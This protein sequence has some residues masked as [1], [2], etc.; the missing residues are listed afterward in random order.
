[1]TEQHGGYR[2]ISLV[3]HPD[4]D[5]RLNIGLAFRAGPS[6]HWEVRF[7][8]DW[9]RLQ[10]IEP[11][12]NEEAYGGLVEWLLG[13]REYRSSTPSLDGL[14]ERVTS[15]ATVRVSEERRVS[16]RQGLERETADWLVSR[17][18]DP[19]APSPRKR[20]KRGRKLQTQVSTWLGSK[21]LLSND[22]KDVTSRFVRDFP[23]TD[24]EFTIDF[25]AKN[26]AWHLVDTLDLRVRPESLRKEK[27]GESALAA[28][29]FD[30]AD[31]KLGDGLDVRKYLIYAGP[32]ADVLV[33][34]CL[35]IIRPYGAHV[36]NFE[37]QRGEVEDLLGTVLH[38]H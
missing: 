1:M 34:H 24:T 38:S 22:Q 12:S 26:G 31:K 8:P 17:L 10:A 3:P 20:Y 21:G 11:D 37:T 30:Q 36:Y 35:N 9:R 18:V 28:L 13:M 6:E 23:I 14:L 25:A 29:A 33:D 7:S 27:V 16:F 4:R 19:P 15:L 32:P 5:E 2:V